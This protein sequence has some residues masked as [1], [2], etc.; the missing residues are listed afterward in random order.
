MATNSVA[1][2]V[3]SIDYTSRDFFSI[4]QDMVNL[5]P[6]TAPNWTNRDPAD[7]GITLLELFAYMGDILNYYIDV[8]A[9]E[10]FITTAVQRQ[11]VLSLATL[12]GYT[13]TD[14]VASKVSLTFQNATSST[15]TLPAL[16]QVATSLVAN[17]TTSQILFEVDFNSS[18]TDGSWTVPAN[19]SV[20]V[21]ATQGQTI[22]NEVV[23]TSTNGLYQTYQLANPSVISNSIEVT[24][25]GV[26]YQQ[27]QYLIDSGPY[28]A[29]YQAVTNADGAT[30]I[31]FG[32]SVSGRVPP[33]GLPI[34][35][36][37]RIGGGVVGNV[38]QNTIK[39]II[40]VPGSS[41]IPAGLTVSNQ[42]GA[43]TGGADPETADSIR[44]NAPLSIR[45]VNRAV[46]KSDYANL[47]VQVNGVSKAL[48]VANVYSSVTLYICPAGDPGVATDNVTP[49]TTFNTVSNNVLAYL[50]DK[51]PANTTITFQP[52]TYVGVNL[53][54]NITV[55][56][57]Y[58][59]SSVLS[60][61]NAAI[62]ELLSI[63]NVLFGYTLPVSDVYNKVNPIKGVAY[64]KIVKMVRADQDQTYT[65]TNKALNSSNVAT[66]TIGTHS[67]QVGQTVS[68]SGVDTTFNGTFVITAVTSTTFSY[69]LVAGAVSSTA[70]S[71][72]VMALTVND[73]VCSENEIPTL[74]ALGGNTTGVGELTVNLSGGIL[75]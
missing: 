75:N 61:V 12:I 38:A 21:T 29:V 25:G 9:N 13:P 6:N 8:A 32:D 70:S 49:T 51:A 68:I 66:L 41:S 52:P 2:Y 62:N 40:K 1:T 72:S 33:S 16:T 17:A 63:D 73:I 30:F 5:I 22:S 31:E 39:Y 58:S 56:S 42:S 65:V 45:S 47:A 37:Y 18:T 36:T 43:A 26:G 71:G 69:T 19:G 35:A 15:T 46:S 10:G 48:A 57:K 11:S 60:N 23:G 7:F 67:L 28:D 34:Y 54:I 4:L 24:I 64:Q 20:S 44:I 59:Q 74:S 55:D 14:S 3:P 53:V 50:Q 27:V